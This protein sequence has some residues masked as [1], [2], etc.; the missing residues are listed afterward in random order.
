MQQDATAPI[1]HIMLNFIDAFTALTN[2][3]GE[4]MQQMAKNI[5]AII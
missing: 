4:K 5:T 3:T 1:A 2:L